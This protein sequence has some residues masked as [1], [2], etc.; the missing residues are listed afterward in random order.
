MA[1]MTAKQEAVKSAGER[2]TRLEDWMRKLLYVAIATCAMMT[3]TTVIVIYGTYTYWRISSAMA[4][5]FDRIEKM[6]FPSITFPGEPPAK[7]D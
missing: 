1:T 7:G 3:V 4:E 6:P 2:L 5:S